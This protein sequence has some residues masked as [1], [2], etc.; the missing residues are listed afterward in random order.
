[1]KIQLRSDHP[2]DDATCKAKTG[3][4]FS[5]WSEIL[6]RRAEGRRKALNW[7]GEQM[8]KDPWWPTTV[9]VE[10]ER[11]RGIVH[12]KDGRAEGYNICVTKTLPAPF[13]AV[14][15]AFTEP[16]SAGWLGLSEPA[17]EGA[18]FSDEHGNRGTWLRLRPSKDLRFGW[19]TVGVEHSTQV[20]VA[21]ADKGNGKTGITLTHQR[22]QT[23][24]EAD[25]LREA[26]S[27]G[28]MELKAGFTALQK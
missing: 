24:A 23:R 26:W 13:E 2:V 6:V 19:Q 11:L 21:L 20:D 15:Q 5:E 7:L 27:A 14:Y 25:G 12:K 18:S 8:G 9:W 17:S 28:L 10:H 16:A 22:L 4:T 3:R 1:M